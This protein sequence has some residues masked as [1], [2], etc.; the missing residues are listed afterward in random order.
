MESD[1]IIEKL[2]RR[3][4]EANLFYG[5]WFGKKALFK[6]RIPKK[7]RLNVL[8]KKIRRT[9]TVNEAKALIKVKL[10]G[11]NVPEVFEINFESS[12]II[13]QF[14]QGEKLKDLMKSLNPDK[15]Q[16]LFKD[17]GK[18]IAILHIHGHIHGDITTSNMIVTSEENVFLI[19][20]GLHEYSDT[21]EDK[22]V[23]LH[24][25]KRV[26]ISSH[27]DDF[28]LSFDAFLEGYKTEYILNKIEDYREI[29]KNIAVIETRGRYINKKE[30]RKKVD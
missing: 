20:F 24:L 9:R 22:S 11:I 29:I 5:S 28:K 16:K 30:E 21:I 1:V 8:D 25:L 4:A 6:I 15:K 27:G 17:V 26:L 19:D 7:Y 18:Q 14:I 2:V 12:T 3:G 23:D 13:M 10:Y